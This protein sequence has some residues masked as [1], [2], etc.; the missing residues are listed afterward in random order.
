V[1]DLSTG[2]AAKILGISRVMVV[3]LTDKFGKLTPRER[4]V[5]RSHRKIPRS[6]IAEYLR[7]NNRPI[8]EGL[9]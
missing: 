2:E 9:E 5:A 3:K 6:E 7:R 1:N 4:R 8:P